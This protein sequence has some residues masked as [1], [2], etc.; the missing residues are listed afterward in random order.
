[1]F[2]VFGAFVAA[3]LVPAA[4]SHAIPGGWSSSGDYATEELGDPWDFSNDA[5]WD[6]QARVES[7]NIAN[8]GVSGGTM[9]FDITT[10]GAQGY[11]LIGSAHYGSAALQ[12][13]SSTWLRPIVAANYSTIVLR[14]HSSLPGEAPAGLSFYTCG[15]TVPSCDHNLS[16]LMKQGWQ[17]YTFSVGPGNGWT[18]NVYSLRFT[19]LHA[20]SFEIDY[21]RILRSGGNAAPVTEP[22]PVVLDPDRTGGLDYA[23]ASRGNA[24]DFNGPDDVAG[25]ANLDN[26]SFSN[27]TMRAC[28]TNND[29]GFILPVTEPID[30]TWFNRFTA[31]IHF[32]G[33]FSLADAPGGG[34]NARVLFRTAGSGSYQISQ[35]IVVYPGWNEIDL[36]LGTNPANAMLEEGTGGPGWSGQQIV[37]I[38]FDPHEDRGVRCFTVDDI[39]LAIVDTAAPRFAI[40]FRDDANGIGAP[41]GGTTAEVFLDTG[42]GGFGGTRVASGIP[43]HGGVNTYEFGGGLSTGFYWVWVRLTDGNG[44]Q[45]SAYAR[46]PLL[47]GPPQPLPAGSNTD[48]DAGVSGSAALVNLTMTQAQRAGYIT[49]DRCDTVM[50]V[51]NTKSNGNYTPGQDI[52]NLSVVPLAGGHFCIYNQSPVHEVADVQGVF[53]GSG[54][55]EFSEFTPARFDT[56]R[57]GKPGAGAITEVATGA[58]GGTEAVLVNLTMTEADAAGYITADRCSALRADVNT[59]PTGDRNFSN[60]NYIVGQNIANLAVVRIDGDGK[61]CIYNRTPVNVVADVQGRF[62]PSGAMR[63]DTASTNRFDTRGGARPGSGSLTTVPTGLP[64]GTPFALVNLTMTGGLGGGYLTADR[65]CGTAFANRF[66]KSN[67]NFVQGRDIANL[68]VVPLAA[69]G[70]FCVYAETATH[71]VVDV[72]GSFRGSNSLGL[73]LSG[74]TRRLDTRL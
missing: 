35:D 52:A 17:T 22:I 74:P 21:L 39:K 44:R 31:R 51:R 4:V 25:M 5:D 64:A 67:G 15:E 56:R 32:E 53:S 49:A 23:T 2:G 50:S 11:V 16:F 58:P 26:V 60:G 14:L 61:F 66:A 63:F 28:N 72:Q 19:S 55:L 20:G 13:G 42:R 24:W 54:N 6:F 68:S 33:G 27:G 71:F 18:G 37:E 43:V 7:R 62:S 1:V 34:M 29:P 40:K 41:S 73:S 57:T 12:W 46:A 45:S 3:L 8:A 59:N 47:V 30:G 70:T 36:E 69:D 38:R 48:V 9:K 10:G 65:D